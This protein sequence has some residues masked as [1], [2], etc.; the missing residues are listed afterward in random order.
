MTG[1]GTIVNMITIIIGATTGFVLKRTLSERVTDTIM[2][3]VGL[4]VVIIGLS[5]SLTSAFTI[6]EGKIEAEHIL[7]MIVSLSLG[8]LIGEL[9]NIENKLKILSE[10]CEKKLFKSKNASSSTFAQGIITATLVFCVG[11]M[12]II[13]AFEDGIN[14]NRDVLFSKSALD[15]ISAVI[16]ASTMGLGVLFSAVIV[17]VYQGLITLLAV[18]IEPYLS[19][20]VITQMTLI[21]SVLIMAIGLNLLKIANIK[22]GNLLPAIFIP[23]VAHFIF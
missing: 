11:S 23:I 19:E 10:I 2:Q 1:L 16:F 13:G 5:G 17:G 9:V 21:G 8:G 4:A 3:G 7:L 12:A 14:D 6:V 18:V 20:V 15:G 22:V